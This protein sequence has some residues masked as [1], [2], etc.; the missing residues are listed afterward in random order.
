[1]TCLPYFVVGFLIYPAHFLYRQALLDGL[2]E[3]SSIKTK[4]VVLVA[5]PAPE[6]TTTSQQ[7][8]Q[9][10]NGAAPGPALSPT[11]AGPTPAGPFGSPS[12]Q[13]FANSGPFGTVGGTSGKGM[14]FASSSAGQIVGPLGGSRRL[15]IGQLPGP[16]SNLGGGSAGG[17]TGL[18]ASSGGGGGGGAG[19]KALV[20]Q[21][22]GKR[23][24]SALLSGLYM[25]SAATSG[26][27]ARPA[28]Q[29]LGS[30]SKDSGD[31]QQ[32]TSGAAPAD[33]SSTG[34]VPAGDSS[35]TAAGAQAVPQAS[36]DG[37]TVLP[38][39]LVPAGGSS[40]SGQQQVAT[41][42]QQL[43]PASGNSSS[44]ALQP[45]QQGSAVVV[46]SQAQ[47][48]VLHPCPA[49]GRHVCGSCGQVVTHPP[50]GAQLAYSGGIGP[51]QALQHS[52]SLARPM[53][54]GM[55]HRPQLLGGPTGGGLG[56]AGPAPGI[57]FSPYA[58][59]A[60]AA[61]AQGILGAG[62]GASDVSAGERKV[63]MWG[64]GLRTHLAVVHCTC[65]Q[66]WQYGHV[67]IAQ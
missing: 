66:L 15:S 3:F 65:R 63:T 39:A 60:G 10:A 36:T 51:Q 28:S 40:T 32:R 56:A 50:A 16:P 17:A 12:Q 58:G 6:P 11:A 31:E 4:R 62:D 46:G 25:S 27:G 54:P 1:M 64:W 13:P 2:L 18:D 47:P 14:S 52:G 20:H 35:S 45:V 8:Q 55:F 59:M 7:Q 42:T 23:A 38:G 19:Q 41:A 57:A 43:I 24:A 33:A 29:P 5:Q 37:L 22:S 21:L 53:L 26:G 48:L 9:T 34:L 49:C 61:A 67:P 30:S 44:T